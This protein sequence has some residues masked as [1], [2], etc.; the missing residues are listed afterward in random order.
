ARQWKL[1]RERA[2]AHGTGADLLQPEAPNP[3]AKVRANTGEAVAGDPGG[4]QGE[5][6][7]RGVPRRGRRAVA[8]APAAECPGP[9][10]QRAPRRR[11]VRAAR[12]DRAL[13]PPRGGGGD[14]PHRLRRWVPRPAGPAG[15]ADRG[16]RARRAGPAGDPE[17]RQGRRG[18]RRRPA[19]RRRP[20]LPLGAAPDGWHERRRHRRDPSPR[21]GAEG[22]RRRARARRRA[23]HHPG[24]P[25]ADRRIPPHPRRRR[26][27][28]LRAVPLSG[29]L[30]ERAPAPR[31]ARGRPRPP[32]GRHPHGDAGVGAPDPRRERRQRR[33]AHIQGAL[34][35][36]LDEVSWVLTSYLAANAIVLP[37]TGWLTARLGR[38]RFFLL[39]T[40]LFPV[41][42]FLSAAAPNVEWLIGA[43]VL[44]GLGGGP[45]IPIAQAVLWEIFPPRQRGM[46]MAVW[47]LGIVLAPTF[48]PTV[49]GYIADN[50]SWRWIFY[51]NLPIGLVGFALASV[52]LFDSPHQ[53]P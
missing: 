36:G 47:G 16:H 41:S 9:R 50:W 33:P 32:V 52:L 12:R 49:G 34:S 51:I 5:G 37:A 4:G 6:Q 3:A 42:S 14:H 24:P 10:G 39:C 8:R 18:G 46:A 40:V 11:A 35:A 2:P 26:E 31:P 28:P 13:L 21:A 22:P 25:P 23:R 1:N 43:R 38:R 17:P 45:V 19:S 44:Q 48:G 30:G 7:G 27:D 53:K 29:T 15:P 20:R